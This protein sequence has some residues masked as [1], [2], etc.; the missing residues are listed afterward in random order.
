M[1]INREELKSALE[2]VKPGLASKEVIPQS[3]SFAFLN[4]NIVTYNDEISISHPIKNLEITG[5]IE[6]TELYKFISKLKEEEIDID[7]N[8]ESIVLKSGRATAGFV[9]NTEIKLP[10]EQELS[11]KSKWKNL[12]EGFIDVMKFVSMSCSNDLSNPKLT[13][14]H[15]N[16]NGFMEASDNFRVCHHKIEVPF[17]TVLIPGESVDI[18]TKMK[19]NKV[20]EGNGWIH[21]KTE[22]GTVI[23]CRLFNDVFVDTSAIIKPV[24]AGVEI[25]FPDNLGEILDR[26]II[27]VNKE[28][29]ITGV[30]INIGGKFLVVDSK[31][32]SSWFTEKSRIK[33]EG[34]PISFSVTPYLLKDILSKTKNC[35]L[36]DKLLR[37]TGENWVYVTSLRIAV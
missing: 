12:S 20:S 21:F 11:E 23:S 5:A 6:A 29:G 13:C 36:S 34:E 17:S 9:L 7:I 33:Y 37:F 19:P 25:T 27:F 14:V 8:E 26:A 32:E 30:D 28:E 18:V 35:L 24:K 4:G 2:I 15:I 10:I 1:K 16:E 3:T 31:T 22:Y